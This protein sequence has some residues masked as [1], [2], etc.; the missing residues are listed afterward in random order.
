M[1][2][3]KDLVNHLKEKKHDKHEDLFKP[4]LLGKLMKISCM[5][6][7]KEVNLFEIRKEGAIKYERISDRFSIFA[8][9]VSYL[10]NQMLDMH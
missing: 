6:L 5:L 3:Q 7:R 4:M 2:D 8:S 9:R 10:S 1:R